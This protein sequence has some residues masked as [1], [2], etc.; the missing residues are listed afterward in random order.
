MSK[1]NRNRW[2]SKTPVNM[3]LE[4]NSGRDDE[5]TQQV[6]ITDPDSFAE[7]CQSMRDDEPTQ[8]RRIAHSFSGV[9]DEIKNG[10]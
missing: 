6:H 3:A 5:P 8:L 9:I 1:H 10:K 2:K 7:D 4:L